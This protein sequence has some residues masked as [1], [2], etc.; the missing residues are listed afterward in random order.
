MKS[1]ASTVVWE[2]SHMKWFFQL[3][4]WVVQNSLNGMQTYNHTELFS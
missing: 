2:P 4:F 1:L 3:Y